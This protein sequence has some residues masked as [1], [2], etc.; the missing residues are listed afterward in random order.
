MRKKVQGCIGRTKIR[1]SLL[2]SVNDSTQQMAFLT[3]LWLGQVS[4]AMSAL[5]I[6]DHM[7]S[8]TLETRWDCCLAE[9][10][11]VEGVSNVFRNTF[12]SRFRKIKISVFLSPSPRMSILLFTIWFTRDNTIP[13]ESYCYCFWWTFPNHKLL[14][15]I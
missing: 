14:V 12:Q 1:K 4:Q 11:A 8:E 15:L 9:K 3:N 7:W 10:K 6:F 13:R 2:R 5:T